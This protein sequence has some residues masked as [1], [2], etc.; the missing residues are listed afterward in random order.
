MSDIQQHT[1]N[2]DQASWPFDDDISTRTFT[3]KNIVHNNYP[4]LTVAHD[5]DGDWQFLCGYVDD[6]ETA[7]LSWGKCKLAF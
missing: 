7:Y 6:A 1:H 4:I 5:H 3:T 2:I